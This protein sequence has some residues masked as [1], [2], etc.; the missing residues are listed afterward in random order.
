MI[1]SFIT[2]DSYSIHFPSSAFS[3]CF[4]RSIT[5]V[6]MFLCRREE[7]ILAMRLER[8]LEAAREAK[9]KAALEAAKRKKARLKR[10]TSKKKMKVLKREVS[11]CFRAYDI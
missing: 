10:F 4:S 11:C 2:R 1:S 9:R 6:D 8:Q 7:E 3:S 5:L